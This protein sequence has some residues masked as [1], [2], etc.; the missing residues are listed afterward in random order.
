MPVGAKKLVYAPYVEYM[1]PTS[2]RRFFGNRDPPHW[3]DAWQHE[4]TLG[5]YVIADRPMTEQEWIEAKANVIDLTQT[6]KGRE[7][8]GGYL[9]LSIEAIAE[10]EYGRP[11]GVTYP[12]S[13]RLAA[14]LRRD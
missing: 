4:H 10:A 3:R 14:I 1:P 13:A 2:P 12:R 11:L 7:R 9:F 6:N 8:A 5:K